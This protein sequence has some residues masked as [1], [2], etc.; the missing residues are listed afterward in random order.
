MSL[1][2]DGYRHVWMPSHSMANRHGFVMEHVVIAVAALGHPLPDGAEIHHAN[3]IKDD[4]RP[5]NLV[6]CQDSAYHNF[7]HRRTRAYLATGNAN[8]RKCH[9]CKIWM[10]PFDPEF[11]VTGT[12]Q[13]PGGRSYH[14]TCEREASRAWRAAATQRRK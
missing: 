7:L 14:L 10:L 13:Q 1:R 2:S 9:H 11:R 6:I 5:S 8:S 3:E 12:Q 4:N